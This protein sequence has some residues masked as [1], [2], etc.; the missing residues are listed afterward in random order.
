MAEI[1]E[2]LA[3]DEREQ[4]GLRGLRRRPGM[5]AIRK[6]VEQIKGEEWERF[7]G[8]TGGLGTR[9]GVV[10]GAA[11]WRAETEGTGGAGEID[12]RSVGA[13]IQRF[14]QRWQSDPSLALLLA[15]AE[16]DLKN[17]SCD[18]NPSGPKRMKRCD[19][20]PSTPIHLTPIHPVGFIS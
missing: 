19:P 18:P 15:R 5:E 9:P 14:E 11:A 10:L 20:N 6:V 4:T 1:Q 2:V 7:S 12:Y 17:P 8:S 16:K 13:A 3:G